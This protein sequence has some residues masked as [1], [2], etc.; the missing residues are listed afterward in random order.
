MIKR[1]CKYC[2]V[3]FETW[4]AEIKKGGGK[5]HSKSCAL[6]FRNK[7]RIKPKKYF[8]CQQCGK[9][10]TPKDTHWKRRIPKYCDSKCHAVARD[11]KQLRTC[12]FCGKEFRKS[13]AF[14]RDGRGIFHSKKCQYEYQKTLI[15]EKSPSF[16]HG[17][18]KTKDYW[19]LKSHERRVK[20]QNNGGTYTIQEW[21]ALKR[22]H[23]Y[24][25]YLCK[26]KEP[27][28]KLTVDHIVPISLG[29]NNF[30]ENIQPLCLSCNCK[31]SIKLFAETPAGQLIFIGG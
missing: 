16:V 29:G 23:Q 4:P 28:V 13:Q 22:R 6:A 18:S 12:K 15:G 5:F 25:C 11:Q 26:R 1:I 17:L 2:G 20:K 10:F 3:T 14:I 19:A 30:I 21:E 24:R 9:L 7:Q 27:D 8:T 31:K